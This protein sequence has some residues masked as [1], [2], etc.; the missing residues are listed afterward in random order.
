MSF[1]NQSGDLIP[2]TEVVPGQA[3]YGPPEKSSVLTSR[4]RVRVVPQTGASVGTAGAGGGGQQIQFLLADQG[5]LIDLRSAVI[6]YTALVTGA[7]APCLD[8]GHPFMS[9]QALLN[10]QLLENIQN[11]PKATNIEMTMGGSQSYYRTAGSMQGFELLNHDLITAVPTA[12][13]LPGA[14]GFVGGIQADIN[15][16][17]TR[18]SAAVFAGIAGEQRSTPLSLIFGLAR[19]PTYLPVSILGELGLVFQTGAAGEVLFSTSSSTAGDYSLSNISIEYDVVVPDP[20]YFSLLQRMATEETGLVMP[21]ESSVIATAASVAA[22]ATATENAFVVSRATNNLLR[23][24]IV[25]V[26]TA[27]ASSI[28][29]PSQSSF[30]HAGLVSAQWRIGSLVYPQTA[31]SGD[32]SLFNMSLCAYGSAV[33]EQG[34]ITNRCLWGNSTNGATAGTAAVYETAQAATGGTAKFAYADRCV[35]SYGFQ[36]IRGGSEPAAVD[37]VSVAGASGSQVIIS[38]VQAPGVAYTP[39]VLLTALR[40][41][42]ARQ[43]AV[44]IVGA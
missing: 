6:N 7:S 29:Y 24:S 19:M 8:D 1:T 21:Y 30:S 14:W 25:F 10:G 16:R 4:R 44:S 33:N 36:T 32:A 39:Y 41:I 11:A 28:S 26:P 42:T 37:G 35:P 3:S 38:V 15:T 22:S 9:A 18:A 34:T 31:S 12:A 20:R 17:Q 2:A 40:F 5:G 27:L 43:G 23:S 13:T